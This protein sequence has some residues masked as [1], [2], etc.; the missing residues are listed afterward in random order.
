[1]KKL[2]KL[3]MLMVSSSLLGLTLIAC[4]GGGGGS[5]APPPVQI[6]GR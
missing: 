6:K 3:T 1:M 5:A 4:G 2:F